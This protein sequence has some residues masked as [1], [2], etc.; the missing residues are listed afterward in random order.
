MKTS[1]CHFVFYVGPRKGDAEVFHTAR[2][3]VGRAG[4]CD[5]H[6]ESDHVS[7]QHAEI[8]Q[9]DNGSYSLYD[10]GTRAGTYVNGERVHDHCGLRS[11]DYVRFG[12]EGPEVIFRV[13]Q[14]PAGVQ[15]L[16]Q[17]AQVSAELEFISGSDAG[18]VFVIETSGV[19]NMGRR[20]ELEVPLDPQGD[21]IVSGNHCNIRYLDGHFV[22]SDTSRNGTY[23]N[24]DLVEQPMEILDKDIIMLGDGGPRARFR[25]EE[26]RQHYPNFRVLEPPAAR[27]TPEPRTTPGNLKTPSVRPLPSIDTP[28]ASSAPFLSGA[29]AAG[30]AAAGAA[31][32][33]AGAEDGTSD[34]PPVDTPV[35]SEDLADVDV[36]TPL[37]EAALTNEFSEPHA[38][39][40]GEAVGATIAPPAEGPA[41]P[42]TGDEEPVNDEPVPEE[43]AHPKDDDP[44][45]AAAEARA[46][47]NDD[48][49]AAEQD[50]EFPALSESSI[51]SSSDSSVSIPLPKSGVPING[52][53]IAVGVGALA[54]LVFII[55]LAS[56]GKEDK[57]SSDYAKLT[58]KLESVK[59]DDADF[60]VKVPQN[61]TT[62][63]SG[64]TVSAESTDKN[65]I[66]DYTRDARLT[67]DKVRQMLT[68]DNAVLS[69]DVQE[70]ETKAGTAKMLTAALGSVRR[71]AVLHQP[72]TGTP[73]VALMETSEK[74]FEEIDQET[75]NV[76]LIDNLDLPATTEVAQ[77]TP[78]PTPAASPVATSTAPPAT[79][80]PQPTAVPEVEVA[81][82]TTPAPT[83]A[84]TTA[85]ADEETTTVGGQIIAS[86][87]MKLS[88]SIDEG[89]TGETDESEGGMIALEDNKGMEIRI[90]RDPNDLDPRATFDELVEV[91]WENKGEKTNDP[92]YQA[93]EFTNDHLNLLLIL[94]PEK[95]GTTLVVYVTS[96]KT[97]TQEQRASI[98]AILGQILPVE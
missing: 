21:M 51:A 32:E 29:A 4:N 40:L 65:I 10:L 68:T 78:A 50:E 91:G 3:T 80:E 5:F 53:L 2:V 26:A 45:I 85:D 75:L 89:W 20:A 92:G 27:P 12:V 16:P 25:V 90:A 9:E 93:G 15:P 8:I 77:S 33:G 35:E 79:P 36:P 82:T 17:L 30:G 46:D 48:D 31:A 67:E 14:P 44:V 66:L 96:E 70:K 87:A 52:K 74:V 13:G 34:D 41:T 60:T 22:L 88:V 71:V 1:V 63:V 28:L 81:A 19:T 59:N 57:A 73:A 23:V 18:K 76:L 61:W 6:L 39:A 43:L 49:S 69:E 64:P 7:P 94:V 97:F 47:E 62:V 38:D 56:G 37:G 55:M 84:T 86:E 98:S 42:P 72:R 11:E 24:G 54:L 83:P 58:E 95:A